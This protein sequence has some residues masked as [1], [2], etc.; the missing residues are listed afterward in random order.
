MRKVV[1]PVIFIFIFINILFCKN[2]EINGSDIS[3]ATNLK[4]SIDDASEKETQTQ[5]PNNEIEIFQKAK[6]KE[7]KEIN[8]IKPDNASE[9]KETKVADVEKKSLEDNSDKTQENQSDFEKAVELINAND[10]KT[11][12]KLLENNLDANI[13]DGKKNTLLHIASEQGNVEIIELL[14]KF[15]AQ[16]NIQNQ[17]GKTPLHFAVLQNK[18]DAINLLIDNGA[19]YKIQDNDG[20]TPL[21]H[22]KDY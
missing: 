16:V 2:K 15:D 20:K 18:K 7:E 10:L 4:T 13:T 12:N 1:L 14:L 5:Q 8:K 22:A 19:D 21:S 11:L 3:E 6:N 17:N 9:E